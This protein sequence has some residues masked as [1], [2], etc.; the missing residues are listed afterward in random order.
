MEKLKVFNDGNNDQRLLQGDSTLLSSYEKV[1]G[2][3]KAK[4]LLADPPYCLLVRRNKKTGQLRDQKQAKINHEVVTRFENVKE[5]RQFTK[6]WLEL[7]VKFIDDDGI[8]C[9]W[10]NFLGRDPIRTIVN[11]LGFLYEYKEFNWCKLTKEKNSG[12]EINGR[13]YEVALIFSKNPEPQI[14]LSDPCHTHCVLTHYD[15]EKEGAQWDNHPNHK[16]FS[17]NE[18][19]IRRFTKVGDRVLD[20]FTGS[21]STPIASIRLGRQISG[22]EITEK[23]AKLSKERVNQELRK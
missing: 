3:D 19:L 8:L 20:P 15:E 4:L 12:N 7:A 13:L 22:I 23:W 6:K 21:G 14:T 9:I 18:P 2:D 11:D 16:T 5:Y 10:T 1:M 17:V